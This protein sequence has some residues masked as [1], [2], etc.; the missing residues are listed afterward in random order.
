MRLAA[1]PVG[2]TA[3]LPVRLAAKSG[4]GATF[5]VL[6]R[7]DAGAVADNGSFSVVAA[8]KAVTGAWV[9]DPAEQRLQVVALALLVGDVVEGPDGTT[10]VVRWV[11]TAADG[12]TV[13][14]PATG[15]R[16]QYPA[17]GWAVIGHV[18]LP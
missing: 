8:T 5:T 7:D 9:G 15:T 17:E 1:M 2:T 14:S 10:A 18:T 3:L 6:D 13:W 4:A 12:Q 11:G 16:P